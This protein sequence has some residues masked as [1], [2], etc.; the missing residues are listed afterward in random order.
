MSNLLRNSAKIFPPVRLTDKTNTI[1][2]NKLD[3]DW[4]GHFWITLRFR[5]RGLLTSKK[6]PTQTIIGVPAIFNVSEFQQI[7]EIKAL[8]KAIR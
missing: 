2:K 7:I 4:H 1:L 6:Q 8:L 3:N 5:P